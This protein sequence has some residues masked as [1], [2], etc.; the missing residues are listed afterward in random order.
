[1][2]GLAGAFEGAVRICRVAKIPSAGLV[3][4]AANML[5]MAGVTMQRVAP[6]SV[7]PGA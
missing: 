4:I 2:L 3:V 6:G 7:V 5:M 1:M